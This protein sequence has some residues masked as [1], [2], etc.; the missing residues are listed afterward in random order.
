M[1]TDSE[2]AATWRRSIKR[3]VP[4]PGGEVAIQIRLMAIAADRCAFMAPSFIVTIFASVANE[5][6]SPAALTDWLRDSGSM[7][8]SR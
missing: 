3:K 4:T 1:D 7:G 8:E 5:V 6:P 2:Q